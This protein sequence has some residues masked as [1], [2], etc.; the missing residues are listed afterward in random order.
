MMARSE[1]ATPE[2]SGGKEKYSLKIQAT[3]KL[4]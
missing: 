3:F 4:E 2:V 1:M